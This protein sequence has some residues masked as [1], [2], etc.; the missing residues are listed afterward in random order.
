MTGIQA[1]HFPFLGFSFSFCERGV[2]STR[3]LKFLSTSVIAGIA[4]DWV[5]QTTEMYFSQ[6]EDWKFPHQGADKVGFILRSLLLACT[7]LPSPCYVHVF[8]LCVLV[9]R[10]CVQCANSLVVLTKLLSVSSCKCTDPK[11]R[12]PPS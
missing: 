10:P 9:G 6:S 11:V 4:M 12:A 2:F 1:T 7:Q 3:Y 8:S 5:A